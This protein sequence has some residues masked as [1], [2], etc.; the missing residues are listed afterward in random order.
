MFVK[1]SDQAY[2]TLLDAFT[3]AAKEYK[4]QV[5]FVTV[6]I[7]VEDN[8]RIMDFFGM[9]EGDVCG[10]FEVVSVI[11]L[12]CLPREMSFLSLSRTCDRG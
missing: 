8:S 12:I 9:K 7:D 2:Q 5:L 3:E 6:D 10:T 11:G 4:G 1:K